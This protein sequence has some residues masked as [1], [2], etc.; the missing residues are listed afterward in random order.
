VDLK[1]VKSFLAALNV[2]LLA[3][4]LG[5]VESL[6]EHPASM[7]HI[8]VPP[9]IRKELGILD[10]FIRLAV[11]IEDIEDLLKDIDNALNSFD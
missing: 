6:A 5:G 11:G 9:E 4:S 3:E 8:S 1:K 2:F 7:T 10:G